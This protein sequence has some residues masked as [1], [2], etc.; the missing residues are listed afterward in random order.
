M[1]FSSAPAELPAKAAAHDMLKFMPL[2]GPLRA[3]LCLSLSV[4]SAICSAPSCS[5]N[6]RMNLPCEISFD[7]QPNDLPTEASIYKDEP[8]T[9]EFRSPR[10]TTYLMHP[11]PDGTQRL[12]V[13]FTPTEAGDWTY[14]ITGSIARFN[15]KESRFNVADSPSS[16]GV[17]GI[18]NL[19]HFWT[20]GKKPHLWF[21]AE[22]PV[23]SLDQA[24]FEKW[25]DDRK[26]DGFTHIRAHVLTS[27]ASLQPF[28]ANHEP[29]PAYFAALDDRLLAVAVR[30]LTADLI[31][32]DKAFAASALLARR[33]DNEALI[34][35]LCARYAGL[36]VTWQG[37]QAFEAT[38]GSRALLRDLGELLNRYDAFQHPRSTDARDSSSPLIADRWMNYIIE[39]SANPQLGAVEHQFTEM[40]SVHVV[41]A[42]DPAGFRHELWNAI[43]NGEYPSVSYTALQNDQNVK[44]AQTWFRVISGTRHWELEPYFDVDGGRAVG[45]QEVEYLI[46]AERPGIVEINLPKHKYNPVWVNPSTGDE[47]PM[48]DY[49]GEVLSRA[50]PDNSHDW[51]LTVP[52]DG[53]KQNMAKYYYFESVD[54]PIQE[55]E[56]DASKAPFEVVEPAGDSLSLSDPIP[57]SVKITRANRASRTVQYAWWGESVASGEGAR[58]LG[59][60]ASGKSDSLAKYAPD[61]PN[62]NL[63]VEAINANGKAYEIDKVYE[64]KR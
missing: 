58:L 36:N 34:R 54:P 29:N 3:A 52:R 40:P 59:V 6:A 5:Q 38:P 14:K 51:V 10:S 24:T 37:I 1:V 48:K 64:L 32:A 28:L 7:L 44:A 57:Y 11:F 31:L 56:V 50:T 27:S 9:V 46:Y 45:L 53:E 13:R 26:R 16:T 61:A 15:D 49:K 25:L 35:Y 55:V 23:H 12:R 21:G 19:R 47:I 39:S 8:L 43:A 33:D 41:Q 18:A 30:G 4:V 42:T 60:G 63:R 2:P 62:L 20:T 22:A 17:V